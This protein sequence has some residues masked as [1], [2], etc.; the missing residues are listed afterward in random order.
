VV[1]AWVRQEDP[2]SEW[3]KESNHATG[4]IHRD[5]HP[6]PLQRRRLRRKRR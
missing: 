2:P 6:S 3:I 5:A 1:V 4:R